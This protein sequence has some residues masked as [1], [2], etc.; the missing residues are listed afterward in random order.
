MVG[1]GCDPLEFDYVITGPI[2][3]TWREENFLDSKEIFIQNIDM[4]EEI[5]S[6]KEMRIYRMKNVH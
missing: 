6:E 2:K 4:Y 1:N 3:E 5:Y